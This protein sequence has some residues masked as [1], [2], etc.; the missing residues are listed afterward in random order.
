MTAG[1]NL[2]R[3]AACFRQTLCGFKSSPGSAA[4]GC[5]LKAFFEPVIVEAFKIEATVIL[6]GNNVAVIFLDDAPV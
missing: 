1:D 4:S 2:R 3:K 5:A 6:I